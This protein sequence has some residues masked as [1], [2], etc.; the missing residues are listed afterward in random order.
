MSW[1]G[2]AMVG[3]WLAAVGVGGLADGGAAA[4]AWGGGGV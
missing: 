3:P 4:A 2:K 1:R